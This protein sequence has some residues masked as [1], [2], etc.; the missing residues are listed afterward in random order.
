[1]KKFLFSILA[2]LF[3]ISTFATVRTVFNGTPSPGYFTTFAAAH[4][5]SANGDTIYVMGS[6][7]GYGSQAITK[8]LTIIG[9]GFYPKKDLGVAAYFDNIYIGS[10][11]VVIS[12]IS[13]GYIYANYSAP[14]NNVFIK[15]CLMTYLFTYQNY[16]IS[17][18]IVEG[19]V[20]TGYVQFTQTVQSNLLFRN[21]SFSTSTFSNCI[22]SVNNASFDHN[23]FHNFYGYAFATSISNCLF[24]NNI[25]LTAPTSGTINCQFNNNVTYYPGQANSVV[26]LPQANNTGVNNQIQVNPQ[27]VNAVIPFT[28]NTNYRLAP[29]SPILTAGIAGAQPGVYGGS[30]VYLASGEPEIPVIRSFTIFN[31]TLPATGSL[32]VNIKASSRVDR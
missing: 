21:N 27:F 18:F 30:G 32:N 19:C 15:N 22:Y 28:A 13:A 10:D 1:M 8:K 31:P 14:N 29:T 12:G 20:I 7:A 26:Q 9:P 6:S 2:V 16:P 24:T 17:N 3:S 25:F 23:I 4:T 11:S 5:A